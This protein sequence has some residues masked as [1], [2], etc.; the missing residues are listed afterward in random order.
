MTDFGRLI[1]AM[2]TPF[3]DELKIDYERTNQLIKHLVNTG[4]DTILVCGTTGEPSTLSDE[5]KLSLFKFV[6][7]QVKGRCKVIASTGTNNTKS[8]IELTQKATELGV[9]GILLVTPYYNKPSQDGLYKHFKSIAVS[10]HLPIMLYN[11][12]GRT[13]VNL[14]V[15]TMIRL[16]KI[17]NITSIKEASSD[18]SVVSYLLSNTPTGFKVYSGDD[19]LTLPILSIGG[20]GVV[21]VASH[22]IGPHM[23]AM[24]D[25]FLAGEVKEAANM[26]RKMLPVFEGLFITSNPSPIKYALKT[27]GIPVG[28][29][30]LPL[31]QV[32]EHEAE[33]ITSLLEHFKK[34][35]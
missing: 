8:S 6:V 25:I 17:N 2:V 12:P 28:K 22:I 33:F 3:D 5:E 1:T 26:H 29:V 7:K 11:I 23:K 35:N 31:V 18:L 15:D 10:T 32:N 14:S 19:S 30:R 21:S 24:I 4:T 20:H 27:Q 34:N 16:S 9:D 13:A